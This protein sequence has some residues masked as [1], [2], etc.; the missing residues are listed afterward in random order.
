MAGLGSEGRPSPP[1]LHE[2]I[3]TL[4][5]AREVAAYFRVS[6]QTIYEWRKRPEYRAYLAELER[7]S[8]DKIA[9]DV[10]ADRLLALRTARRIASHP[11]PHAAL[12]A[13]RLL[14]EVHKAPAIPDAPGE[15]V[16]RD[17]LAG[18]VA[19]LLELVRP[20]P[21]SDTRASRY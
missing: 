4:D 21:G 5:S 7:A 17:G 9:G 2:A 19:S 18:K 15:A 1:E 14:L 10:E 20:K 6:F 11:D 13:S 3:R 8:R 12:N 16:E